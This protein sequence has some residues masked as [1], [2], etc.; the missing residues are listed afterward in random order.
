M[1]FLGKGF[2]HFLVVVKGPDTVEAYTTRKQA[3][4]RLKELPKGSA[5]YSAA[6]F[7]RVLI[8]DG[9]LKIYND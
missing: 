4:A 8:D 7:V 5:V 3:N 1:K 9:V 6:E 2:P